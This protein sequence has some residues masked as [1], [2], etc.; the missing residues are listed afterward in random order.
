M[1]E[2]QNYPDQI[3]AGFLARFAAAIIDIVV[4]LPF[5]GAI[6]YIVG[7]DLPQ[8]TNMDQLVAASQM[9]PT[10]DEKIADFIIWTILIAY[11]VYFLTSK[12]QAT[13]GKRLM[14]IY[15]ATR[16]GEKLTVNCAVARS[17]ASIISALTIFGALMI[18]FTKEKTAFHDIICGTRVFYGK[19]Q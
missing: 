8:I 13:I 14:N 6:I 19:K 11:S 4:T 15:V 3:Y 5:M 18:A 9:V 17:F 7:I 12:K 10:S 16:D 2:N 1:T